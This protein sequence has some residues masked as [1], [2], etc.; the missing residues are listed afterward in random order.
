MGTQLA[1]TSFGTNNGAYVAEFNKLSELLA[2]A[3]QQISHA[4][5]GEG[6]HFGN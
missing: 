6:E 3:A 2:D 1:D 4:G 5:E